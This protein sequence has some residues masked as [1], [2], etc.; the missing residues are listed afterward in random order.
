VKIKQQDVYRNIY[1]TM[2]AKMVLELDMNDFKNNEMLL[3][4]ASRLANIYCVQNTWRIYNKIIKN[5]HT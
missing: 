1:Y 2:F 4:K 5:D 3:D